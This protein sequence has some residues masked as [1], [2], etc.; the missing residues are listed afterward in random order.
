[1]KKILRIARFV[2]NIIEGCQRDSNAGIV[3]RLKELEENLQYAMAFNKPYLTK[4]EAAAYMGV[5]ARFLESLLRK[6]ELTYYQP[7]DDSYITYLYR[8]DID[9]FISRR[10]FL[11]K[12]QIK[13]K[14]RKIK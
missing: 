12:D 4:K 8:A 1:M 2:K 7:L 5:S 11:S 10:A 6:K 13:A 9:R 14:S 3:M